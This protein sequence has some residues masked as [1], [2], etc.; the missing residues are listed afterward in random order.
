MHAQV[1]SGLQAAELLPLS[2][3]SLGP[4]PGHSHASKR[5]NGWETL[6]WPHANQLALC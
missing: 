1:S 6:S 2:A 3:P 5:Q 4:Q